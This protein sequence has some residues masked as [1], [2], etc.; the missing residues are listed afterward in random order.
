MG[1]YFR[2][3]CPQCGQRLKAKTGAVGREVHCK[4]CEARI[5]VP[6]PATA[7]HGPPRRAEASFAAAETDPAPMVLKDETAVNYVPLGPRH[8]T[9][10]VATPPKGCGRALGLASL[11]GVAGCGVLLT[12]LRAMTFEG[13]G[14]PVATS[15]PAPARSK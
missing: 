2:F 15:A 6:E 7:K 4:R 9:P 8:A 5:D 3:S 10:G 12:A 11:I 14:P 13:P 1:K